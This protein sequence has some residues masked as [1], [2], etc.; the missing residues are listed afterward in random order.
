MSFW[1]DKFKV[2]ADRIRAR[3]GTTELIAP[4]DFAN[5]V[6]EVYEKG[7]LDR[8][9]DYVEYNNQLEQ[10]M[11]STDTGG[12]SFYDEF[13]DSIQNPNGS[14][15]TGYDYYF[16]GNGWND[17][18]FRPKYDIC[19]TDGGGVSVF[20]RCGVKNLEKC[21]SDAGV[22]LDL[23]KCTNIGEFFANSKIEVLPE[24]SFSPSTTSAWGM[25]TNCKNLHTVRKLSVNPKVQIGTNFSGCTALENIVIEGE[26][27]DN[28]NFQWCT[29]LKKESIVSIVESLSV[30][31]SGKT[32][33]ISTTAV[34]NMVFP[35]TSVQSGITYNS[36]DELISSKTNWTISKN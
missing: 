5:K 19:P 27:I 34:N 32:L 26:I 7:K 25:F 1:S 13:W 11:Y 36:W 12:K 24:L 2:I 9:A 10:I 14:I 6:D 28:A 33:T 21:L 4:N 17:T 18:N 16:M 3:L 30:N 20:Y 35:V 29:K 31:V 23:T 15:R 8:D 22:K